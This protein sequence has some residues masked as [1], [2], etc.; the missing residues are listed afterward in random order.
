[1]ESWLNPK[2][3][4]SRFFRVHLVILPGSDNA[5]SA[6]LSSSLDAWIVLKCQMP[7]GSSI[8][9][10][11]RVWVL[12]HAW[13]PTIKWPYIKNG[14]VKRWMN[15]KCTNLWFSG[16][17][18]AF[19]LREDYRLALGNTCLAWAEEMAWTGEMA[20]S[21]RCSNIGNAD[22]SSIFLRTTHGFRFVC[23]T[24]YKMTLS[25]LT[26]WKFG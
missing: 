18:L 6:G 10:D 14:L 19:A 11:G 20:W 22:G 21:L 15:I 25:N 12:I 1:M 13:A 9:C 5:C 2:R 26:W 4:N 23:V 8:I 17:H 3:A 24:H 16:I 7:T